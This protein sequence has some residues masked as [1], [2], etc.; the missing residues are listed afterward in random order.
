MER[1][2]LE[3]ELAAGRSIE[4]IARTVGRSPSTVA[5]WVNKHGL[6]SQHAAKHAAR[7]GLD[8]DVLVPLVERGL[9]VREIAAE[10]DRSA[11]T[12]LHWLSRHGLETQPA[13]YSRRDT[14]KPAEILRQCDLHG[15]TQYRRVGGKGRYRCA[16][17]LIEA[18]S[19]RRRR[20]QARVDPGGG[21]ALLP[22]RL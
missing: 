4:A 11:T 7:G 14:P 8:R 18:V 22:L 5:Y 20:P 1:A 3:S 13:R 2:W 16:R 19:E 21:R 10:L 9:S 6:V 15:W 17:C 12:V